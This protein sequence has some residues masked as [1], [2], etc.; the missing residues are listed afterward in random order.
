MLIKMANDTDLLSEF[1]R[2]PATRE[3]Q[4]AF[5][6]LVG[7][8][9][10]LVYSVAL[11]KVRSPQ[12]AEEVSQTVFTQLAR[13][14]DALKQGTIL[15]AWLHRVTYYAGIDVVRR[16]ARRQA[17]EQIACE[18]SLL[19]DDN[20]A[21]WNR[22]EPH[23][24]EAVQSLDETD[25]A[26]ILLRFFENKSLREVG[27]TLGT[28]EDAAQKRV[29]R[30]LDR[31]RDYF[32]KQKITTVAGGLAGIISAHGVQAAPAGLSS[33]IAAGSL[34]AASVST[35]VSTTLATA[36]IITM[37]TLQKIAIGAV[38]AGA[39]V[40]IIYQHREVSRLQGETQSLMEEQAR[41][42]A[43]T[44][45]VQQLQQERD[46]ATNALASIREE[47]AS[48]KTRPSEVLKLRGEVGTLRDQKAQLGATTAISKMTATPEAR[49]LL[50]DQQK[51]GMGMIYK[52]F[53]DQM[54]LTPDQTEKVNTLL[55]DHI[56][57]DVDYVTAALR[58]KTPPDQLSQIFAGENATLEQSIQDL[59]GADGV[60]QYRDYTKNLL[61]NLT[62]QQFQDSLGGSDAEKKAKTEQLRQAILQETQSTLAGAG[63][64]ADFQTVPILNFVNIASEQQAAQ[65]LKLLD[66]IYQRVIAGAGSYLSP[67]EIAKLQSFAGKAVANN[68]AALNMNRALMAPISNQ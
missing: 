53:A 24:D 17:R 12:L 54:K 29:G 39:A 61:G 64:P 58:D 50:H 57:Q 60:A 15:A 18:M 1:V 7:Q 9:L 25:R 22:I 47:N 40:T 38:I 44:Q 48:L 31:L 51:L 59:I 49:Q 3:G 21:D 10:N 56:M 63:L 27:E 42:Q 23:L 52:Q 30:A 2:N 62:A 19:M 28:S 14:A 5:T 46:T 67:E 43:L 33:V 11:R 20:A 37:T 34:T 26:A 4:D 16:E 8:H 32:I 6:A 45:Q 41:E 35:S 66:G 13:H 68:T 65:D 36:K 55:A